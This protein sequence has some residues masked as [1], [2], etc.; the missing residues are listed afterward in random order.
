MTV[1]KRLGDSLSEKMQEIFC[2]MD[3]VQMRYN[4]LFEEYEKRFSDFNYFEEKI[5]ISSPLVLPL[6]GQVYKLI[7]NSVY[8]GM[9]R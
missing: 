7:I 3:L 9:I 6:K 4:T 2:W 1:T 8:V 5:N